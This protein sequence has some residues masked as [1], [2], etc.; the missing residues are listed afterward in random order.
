MSEGAISSKDVDVGWTEINLGG[1]GLYGGGQDN[2]LHVA[3]QLSRVSTVQKLQ[4]AVSFDADE[5]RK[6]DEKADY[7]AT[8]SHLMASHHLDDESTS[9]LSA[10]RSSVMISTADTIADKLALNSLLKELR[11]VLNFQLEDEDGYSSDGY[12]EYPT[13]VAGEVICDNSVVLTAFA[14][15]LESNNTLERLDLD[16]QLLFN[17]MDLV[18]ALASNTSIKNLNL[19]YTNFDEIDALCQILATSNTALEDLD[20]SQLSC[21]FSDL[22]LFKREEATALGKA[23]ISNTSL[24]EIN[25]EGNRMCERGATDMAEALKVNS[26]LERLDMSDNMIGDAGA[27]ALAEA[28]DSNT[29]LKSLTLGALFPTSIGVLGGQ[30]L[31]KAWGRSSTIETISLV[32]FFGSHDVDLAMHNAKESEIHK[33]GQLLTFG[34]GIHPR[35]GDD[36]ETA[37]NGFPF[38][39]M[40]DDV[41]RLVG[42]AYDAP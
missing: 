2:S 26:T 9:W 41:F 36:K 15:T 12:S 30:A 1:R 31:G 35:P 11:L 22:C 32:W 33:M 14:R 37:G 40:S 27:L 19:R 29:T 34:M 4:I 20:I 18:E 23:L 24:K 8:I 42:E 13:T 7:L 17:W 38:K 21:P 16:G 25:L 5:G 10:S 28:L 39:G 6:A 3:D